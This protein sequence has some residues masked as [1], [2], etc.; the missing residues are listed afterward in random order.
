M[1]IIKKAA[2]KITFQVVAY[3]SEEGGMGDD[4]FGPVVNSIEE[5]I[6]QL[7][8]ARSKNSKEDCL[9]V[10]LKRKNINGGK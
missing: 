9:M 5:A 8:L 4:Y 7:E 10:L 6:H 2:Y 1:E 3:W